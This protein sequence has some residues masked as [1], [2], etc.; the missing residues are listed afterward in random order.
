MST[1]VQYRRGTTA[2]HFNFI[3]APGEITIDTDL[4]SVRVHDG[5]TSGGNLLVSN[6]DLSGKADVYHIHYL[7][8]I[9]NGE[10]TLDIILNDKANVDHSHLIDDI[11]D[12]QTALDGKAAS[13][14]GHAIGDISDLITILSSKAETVH[15]HT[16]ANVTGLQDALDVKSD[17]GHVHS[18]SDVTGLESALYGKAETIHMHSIEDIGG[19][20]S[21]LDNKVDSVDLS[22]YA[23]TA[24]VDTA[25][26]NLVASAPGALDTLNELS[27]ALGDDPNF[28]TTITNALTGKADAT[29][30][31]A[32][33]DV[34]GLQT[35]LDGKVELDT[36]AEV[37]TSGS[38]NDL[39]EKPTLA[40]V[41]TSGSYSDLLNIPAPIGMH[42][43]HIDRRRLDSYIE[44][45]SADRP[46][47]TIAAAIAKATAN[48]D[49]DSTPYTFMIA[50]GTYAENISLEGTG[51]FD[52]SIVGLGRVAIN[53]ASGNAL[54]STTGNTDLKNLVIRNVEFADPIVITGSNTADQFTNVTFYDVSCAALTATCMNSLN[55]RGGYVSGNVTLTNVAW[56]YWD[57]VQHDAQLVTITSDTTATVPSWGMANA[58]GYFVG[59]KF[60]DFAL[61][62]VGTGNFN[63]NLNNCYTGLS[64]GAYTIPAGFTVNA[65]NSTMRGT[66]TND[67]AMNLYSTAVLNPVVGT[68]TT[69]FAG[70]TGATTVHANNVV[71]ADGTQTG[72]AISITDLKTLVAGS[73]DFAAFQA[74]MA[75]L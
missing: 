62:R 25:I 9:T 14:H 33:T 49:G 51:L 53:P 41:A 7:Q 54:T 30:T 23:S 18:L 72:A 75:A 73:A 71:F 5:I 32:I 6:A 24:Y 34:T 67:G 55:F 42:L 19:L 35:A 52:I 58:G 69:T 12:L 11:T 26:S 22:G 3:G 31:H 40:V 20:Q 66:W 60:Q 8:D 43:L 63:L 21:I 50:E 1:S 65:R 36:L 2:E 46:F 61:N 48:G 57:G 38:Y 27:A 39:I 37:A 74:A 56:F 17:L 70:I 15:V 45:G 64:A 28:A 68:G 59:G 13:S 16:I 29:H 47:K 10:A 44:D 4:W